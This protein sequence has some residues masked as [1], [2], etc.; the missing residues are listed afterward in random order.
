MP[1][2]LAEVLESGQTLIGLLALYDPPRPEVPDA[3]R[4]CSD[5]GIR[6][7]MVTGDYGLTAQA[8][9]L[10]IGL[11]EPA[12]AN[13]P[14]ASDSVDHGHRRLSGADPV[15]VI[16][17]SSLAQI[18]DV[19]LRQLLKYRH[20]LVFARM[21]PEQKL[22]LVQAYRALG[23]VVAVTGDGVNDAPALR[24]ADV[25][26]AMGITGT[27][28]AREAADIVLLDDNFATIVEAVR[29]GRSVV[30]NIGKFITYI[31]ASNVPEVVPFLAMVVVRIPAALTVLQILAVDLGTDLLPALGL[32]SEAPEARVM[33]Q[34]PRPRELPLL[35]RPLMVRA[36]LVLGL[37]EGLLSMAGY[38]MV[39]RNNGVDLAA[40]RQLAPDLLHHRAAPAVLAIQREASTVA[41]CVI[42]ASQMG[43]LLACRSDRRPFW[44]LLPIPNTLLWLGWWS[45]PVVAGT[46]VLVSPIAAVF[47]LAR[48]PLDHLGPIA[49]APLAVLLVDTVHK[50]LLW[51]QG[52]G[53][54]PA[55]LAGSVP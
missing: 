11:L 33:H 53:R 34:P 4:R 55:G 29:F 7:T 49:L 50:R 22:R 30:A 23:E 44:D 20:R 12:A 38:L 51:W 48:F 26:L 18:S 17:G 43:A 39:W 27:D 42:V 45:E 13:V 46:L 54:R 16:D 31:L 9:A 3:I 52:R 41:F 28:V 19:Q 32:G 25:G 8:I 1:S 24:A 21:A 36:Y 15:R 37:V 35:N 14:H 5:A 10:Q 6:V 47:E 2:A 40:L